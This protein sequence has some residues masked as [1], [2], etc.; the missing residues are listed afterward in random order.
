MLDQI[1]QKSKPGMEKAIDRFKEEIGKLRA[2]RANSAMVE[3]LVVDYYG[4]K[5]PLKQ[6]AS[7]NVPEPRLIVIQPWSKDNLVDIEKAINESQLGFNPTSDG[8][9]IR[10]VIPA[11][12]EERRAELVKVLGKYAEAAR[13]AVR[14]AREDIWDEIQELVRQGKM[15][16]DGKFSGKEKLQKIVDEYNGKIEEVRER[17]E[18][19]VMEI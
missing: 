1:I 12:N 2:G 3:N 16:E 17:K 4:S 11:L 19:E 7:I 13:V 6:I 18:K 8:Q 14:Q 9:V 15:G 5:S 10:I